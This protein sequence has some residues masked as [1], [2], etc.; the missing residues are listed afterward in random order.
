MGR[1]GEG[2]R[3]DLGSSPGRSAAK[4]RLGRAYEELGDRER[5]LDA[6][7][8]FLSRYEKADPGLPWVGEAR[9]AVARL[10]G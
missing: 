4:Y 10:G 7:R 2:Q 3:G 8:T 6:Y 1:G 5:A 9:A